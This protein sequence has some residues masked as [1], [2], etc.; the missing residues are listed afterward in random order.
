[1]SNSMA[2]S[3]KSIWRTWSHVVTNVFKL[4]LRVVTYPKS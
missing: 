4:F 3:R 1:M 2:R